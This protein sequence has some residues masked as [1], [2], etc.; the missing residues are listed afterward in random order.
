MKNTKGL[1]GWK[2]ELIELVAKKTDCTLQHNGCPCNT[3]FHSFFG[4]ELGFEIGHKFWEVVLVARGDYTENDILK[5]RY[6]ETQTNI[7]N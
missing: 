1:I 4:D 2:K 5:Y 6:E 3:C 7:K